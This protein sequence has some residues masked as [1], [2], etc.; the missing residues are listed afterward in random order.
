MFNIGSRI[1]EICGSFSSA[2]AEIFSA[3][4][5]DSAKQI[6]ADII[7]IFST[8]FMG[9]TELLGKI[10]RDILNVLTKPIIDNKDEIKKAVQGL[11]DTIQPV[12]SNIKDLL[13]KM[14]D[15]LN[16]AYDTYAKPV[17]DALAQA[18]SDVVAWCLENTGTIETITAVVAAFF[19]AWEV[20]KLGEFIINAGGVISAFQ[21][22][23]AP[24][25]VATTAL[26]ANAKAFVTNTAAKIADKAETVAIVAM[27]AKDFV[28]A[29]AA[30]VTALAT[31]RLHYSITPQSIRFTLQSL[32]MDGRPSGP[33]S[34][35][36][37]VRFP[38]YIRS[39][40]QQLFFMSG[41]FTV[42][43]NSS[44]SFKIFPHVSASK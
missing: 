20:V 36:L 5:S 33:S 19:A 39:V 32:Y 1:V 18:L 42:T 7:G 25:T 4:R 34:H 26:L 2:V 44:N 37:A 10:G 11:L 17:F 9:V 28:V 30:S 43:T 23:F 12:V 21:G 31:C 3:F 40:F 38:G 29:T 15:G 6:T 14:F 35:I 22:M 13:D 16:A 41:N 8:A 24:V 27:Y